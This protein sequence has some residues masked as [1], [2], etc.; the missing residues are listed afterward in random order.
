MIGVRSKEEK[1]N[2]VERISKRK[3]NNNNNNNERS[4]K[5]LP[6]VQFLNCWRVVN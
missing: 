3:K 6:R 5:E 2:Q 1:Y 4:N